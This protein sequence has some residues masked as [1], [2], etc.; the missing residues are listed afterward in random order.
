MGVVL[1]GCTAT[2][3]LTPS[4]APFPATERSWI[5]IQMAESEAGQEGVRVKQVYRTSPAEEAGLVPGDVLRGVEGR[6]VHHP[7]EVSS[8]LR[9]KRPGEVVEVTLERKGNPLRVRVKLEAFPGVEEALRRD[10]VGAVAPEL[11]G[12]VAVQGTAPLTLAGLRGKVVVL[13]FWASWC[14]VCRKT[15]PILNRW[16]ER[17][18][19]QGV[20]VLGVS[21]DTFGAASRGVAS[22]GIRYPVAIDQGETVFPAYGA[23]SL[24]T[25]YV[26]DRRGIVRAVEVGFRRENLERVE[27]LLGELLD[28]KE[29]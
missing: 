1:G 22:F 6:P 4:P 16:H 24:P 25:L 14:V 27:R 2:S 10:R 8:M 28:E 12:L 15:A 17:L 23:S 29:P 11:S 13:D 3:V 9:E 19:A 26:V 18:E 20:V 7:R 21:S 5:G